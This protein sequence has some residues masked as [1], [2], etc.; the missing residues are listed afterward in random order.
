MRMIGAG[1]VADNEIGDTSMIQRL[2]PSSA[3]KTA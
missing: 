1:G 2:Q 3:A